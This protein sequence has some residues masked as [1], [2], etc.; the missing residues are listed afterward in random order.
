MCESNIYLDKNGE[1]ELVFENAEEI[2][3]LDGGKVEIRSMFGEKK[4]L[5]AS[6]KEIDLHGHKIILK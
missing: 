5:S 3:I 6:I 4:V 2:K 1:R